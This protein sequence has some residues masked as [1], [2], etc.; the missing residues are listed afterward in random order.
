M[1]PSYTQNIKRVNL[2]TAYDMSTI[3]PG[4]N[5]RA[6]NYK[7]EITKDHFQELDRNKIKGTM[8]RK[9]CMKQIPNCE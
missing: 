2:I 1:F 7:I 4:L 8:H 3:T 6:I 9:L 5:I